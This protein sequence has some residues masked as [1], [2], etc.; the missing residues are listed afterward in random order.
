M[1]RLG[2]K[3]AKPLQ[4][5]TESTLKATSKTN[6]RTKQYK[7]KENESQIISKTYVR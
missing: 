7:G 2:G 6:K 4:T 5:T 1:R 3:M